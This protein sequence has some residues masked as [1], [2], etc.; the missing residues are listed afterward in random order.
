MALH[1]PASPC[2]ALPSIAGPAGDQ[3]MRNCAG[4]PA[5]ADAGDEV[6][7]AR[8]GQG[9]QR[10][11]EVFASRHVARFLA[12]AQ[13]IIG[14]PSD[15]E[16]IVQDALLRV[17]LH[18]PRWQAGRARATTWLYRIVVNLALDRV[19]NNRGRFV[20][21]AEAENHA[22]P[23]PDAQM[24]AEGRQL[25]HFIARAVA[26]L[27]TRQRVALTLCYFEAMECAE[28]AHVMQISVAAMESLLLR[29]RRTLR[30]RL[31]RVAHGALLRNAP[32]APLR[33]EAARH[34]AIVLAFSVPGHTEALAS[35]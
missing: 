30:D 17:W 16:E 33:R 12:V 21:I 26:E 32:P 5:D 3:S 8:I 35:A 28:A 22:D 31:N 23:A 15:A 14:N 10:A 6:L 25:E 24:V 20:P 9:D 34:A 7:L 29:G 2:E 4:G 11:F 13:R 19:R 27:P 1:D 18:A